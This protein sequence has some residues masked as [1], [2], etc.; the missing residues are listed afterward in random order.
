MNDQ[1]DRIL[2][3]LY[4]GGLKLALYVMLSPLLLL[5]WIIEYGNAIGVAGMNLTGAKPYSLRR[6]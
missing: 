5:L 4:N 1:L 3:K 6:R 2:T